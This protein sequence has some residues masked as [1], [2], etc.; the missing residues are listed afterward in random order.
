M[1]CPPLSADQLANH[2]R[3]LVGFAI[4]V[5]C[6]LD[7]KQHGAESQLLVGVTRQSDGVVW[8]DF[9]EGWS[10]QVTQEGLSI[11]V[12]EPS[13]ADVRFF[14]ECVEKGYYKN[15]PLNERLQALLQSQAAIA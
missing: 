6:V 2:L 7:G 14:T 10:M 5:S 4:E 12:R 8:A 13:A 15:L 3:S 1:F 11:Q 9:V